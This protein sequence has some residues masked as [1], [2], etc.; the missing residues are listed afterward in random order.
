KVTG[1][2]DRHLPVAMT[3]EH[4]VVE[5]LQLEHRD[6]VL[7][8]SGQPYLRSAEM[9]TLAHPCQRGR[10]DVMPP[11]AY[12]PGHSRPLPATAPATAHDHECRHGGMPSRTSA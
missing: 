3:A 8:V 10:E 6:H 1:T 11:L 9:C 4:H 7:H 12:R 2:A 5:I